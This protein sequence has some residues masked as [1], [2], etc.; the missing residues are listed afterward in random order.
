MTRFELR[1]YRLTVEQLPVAAFSKL[2]G[3]SPTT[4]FDY[5]LGKRPIPQS[6]I[7]LIRCL[8]PPAKLPPYKARK[9]LRSFY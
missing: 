2:L 6:L 3:I 7:D 1:E 4:L 9:R 8:D 5:E